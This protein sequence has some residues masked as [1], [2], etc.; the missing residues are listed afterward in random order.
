MVVLPSIGRLAV[1]RLR[2]VRR[3][4]W[5]RRAVHQFDPDPALAGRCVSDRAGG[6][7]K[8]PRRMADADDRIWNAPEPFDGRSARLD[9]LLMA[10]YD[11]GP[12]ATDYGVDVLE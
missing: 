9:L 7:I 11:S 4:C 3:Q 2:Q 6:W 10:K 1:P 12:Y 8:V 5:H